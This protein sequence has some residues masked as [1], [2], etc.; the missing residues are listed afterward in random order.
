ME[1]E[2][3]RER[4]NGIEKEQILLKEERSA[5]KNLTIRVETIKTKF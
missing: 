5:L 3:N 1:K 4:I 2:K